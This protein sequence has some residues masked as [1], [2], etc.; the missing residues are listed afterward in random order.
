MFENY[1]NC[2]KKENC[3]LKTQNE[4]ILSKLDTLLDGD[5]ESNHLSKR[6]QAKNARSNSP[7]HQAEQPTSVNT[8]LDN[9]NV[10]KNLKFTS[11][12]N[13][14]L[15]TN[16]I[17][18]IQASS[19]PSTY[20]AALSQISFQAKSNPNNNWKKVEQTKTKPHLNVRKISE[21]GVTKLSTTIT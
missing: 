16:V 8:I 18:S 2:L 19:I 9:N 17:E 14:N 13:Q 7:S 11:V 21:N 1:L 15:A 10:F 3:D 20:S 12:N 5:N 4:L 6:K